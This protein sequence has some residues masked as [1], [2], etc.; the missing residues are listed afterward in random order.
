MRLTSRP[1]CIEQEASRRGN[2]PRVIYGST[3]WVYSEADPEVVDENTPLHPPTHLYTATKLTSEYYCISYDKLYGLATTILRYG[4]PYG[5]GMWGGLVLK[6]FLDSAFSGKPLTIFGDG[7]ASRRF[8]HVEDLAH[9]HVL[10][11][12]KVA[13]CGGHV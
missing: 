2:V 1:C 7:S 12:Q 8:V 3:T 10:A 9:A 6:N 5:P 13:P 11:L 4:I